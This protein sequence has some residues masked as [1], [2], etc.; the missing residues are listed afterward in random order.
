MATRATVVFDLNGTLTDPGAIGEPWDEDELGDGVLTRALQTAMAETILGAYHDF[1]AHIEDA[2]RV[3]IALRG[4]DPA[5]IAD[6]LE[7][8]SR[9]RPFPDV[10][11]A[12]RRLLA[13]GWR[14]AV[15]TNSGADA[16][17]R[18][19]E[20]AGLAEC[21]ARVLGVDAVKAFK[22][23]PATYAYAAREL[24]S[25]ITYVAS[26]AWDLAGAARAGFRTALTTRDRTYP[27]AFGEPSLVVRDVAEFAERVRT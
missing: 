11:D 16:G 10:P 12:L 24:D 7:Q 3:E 6:A 17:R 4:L 5:R 15:L 20:A 18:A 21:F 19:L 22:P 1:S 14:L 13:G 23:H 8:A 26:H 25:E 9:L 2:L 27:Q